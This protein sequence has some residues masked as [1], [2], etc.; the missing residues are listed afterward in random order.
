MRHVSL[1]AL[2]PVSVI[3]AVYNGERYIAQAIESV[4]HQTHR[5]FEFIIVDDGSTDRTRQILAQYATRD[6]RI[7]I[8]S[9]D[10]VRSCGLEIS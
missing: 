5:D 1:H 6:K 9:R 2:D 8:V 7:E 3:M 4:F 10:M